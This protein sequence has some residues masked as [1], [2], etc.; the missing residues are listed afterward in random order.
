MKALVTR[1][2]CSQGF[3]IFDESGYT[4]FLVAVEA[5]NLAITL[6]L[7]SNPGTQ[8]V[9]FDT[10]SI[11]MR[12]FVHMAVANGFHE[13]LDPLMAKLP[14]TLLNGRDYRGWTPL[15]YAAASNDEFMVLKFLSS[16][17]VNYS[18]TT[19]CGQNAIHIACKYQTDLDIIEQLMRKPCIDINL[20]DCNG[21]SPLDIAIRLKQFDIM[22]LLYLNQAFVKPLARDILHGQIQEMIVNS[23]RTRFIKIN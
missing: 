9:I 10:H 12:S 16:P 1:C 3:R 22:E 15:H 20:T 6:F 8:Y 17:K 18:A 21:E 23:L 11:L 19:D 14:E 2:N 13:I 7:I 4:P 5:E